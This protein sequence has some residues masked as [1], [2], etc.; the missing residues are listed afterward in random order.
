MDYGTATVPS[1]STG[2]VSF[3][4]ATRTEYSETTESAPMTKRPR[5]FTPG[6]IDVRTQEL[7]IRMSYV[8]C[9]MNYDSM[10]KTQ[11]PGAVSLGTITLYLV[12]YCT[13]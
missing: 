12:L 4:G 9:T 5:S 2:I 11:V 10:L 6:S 1:T 8:I 7:A 3:N 13:L